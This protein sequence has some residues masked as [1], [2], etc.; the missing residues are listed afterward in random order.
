M[1][2]GKQAGKNGFRF[3]TDEMNHKAKK[4]MWC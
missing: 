4:R 3:F 1:I 2:H